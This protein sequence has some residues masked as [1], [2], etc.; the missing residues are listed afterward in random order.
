MN[1]LKAAITGMKY[2]PVRRHKL[3]ESR[4]QILRPL[5]LMILVVRM[6]KHSSTSFRT[7]G[8]EAKVSKSVATTRTMIG[9]HTTG[10]RKTTL[11]NRILAIVNIWVI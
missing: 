9:R 5:L 6:H 1:Y 10:K 3:P 2:I 7:G 11:Q 4:D 8:K